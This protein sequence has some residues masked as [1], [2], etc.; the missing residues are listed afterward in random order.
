MFAWQ[1]FHG[2]NCG[3]SLSLLLQEAQHPFNFVH[4]A[5]G[6]PRP[7]LAGDPV[8]KPCHHSQAVFFFNLQDSCARVLLFRDGNKELKNFNSQ[9]PFQVKRVLDELCDVTAWLSRAVQGE[10]GLLPGR[11]LW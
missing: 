9:T 10:L 1:T 8:D 4:K 7:E 5:Q 3:P 2:A 11:L 6:F